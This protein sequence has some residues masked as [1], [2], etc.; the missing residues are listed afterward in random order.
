MSRCPFCARKTYYHG[1]YCGSCAR[2]IWTTEFVVLIVMTT[3]L[4]FGLLIWMIDYF[5]T[6]NN[7]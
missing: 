5:A 7:Y 4:I 2:V 1:V 6:I 3:A